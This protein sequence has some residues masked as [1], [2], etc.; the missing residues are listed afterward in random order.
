[1]SDDAIVIAQGGLRNSNGK[2]THGLIRAGTRFRV[3]AVV[4]SDCAGRDAGEVLD[5]KRRGIPVV[6]TI[7]E[8]LA[9]CGGTPRYCV[10]GIATSGG[11]FTPEIRAL[12]LRALSH[13]MSVVAGLHEWMSE[14]PDMAAMAKEKGVELVDLRRPPPISSLHFW[15][16]AIQQVVAPRVAVL[17]T[18]CALG[19]RTTAL[20]LTN[21]LTETGTSAQ[22]IYTGQ[23]GWMQGTRFGFILD[24]TPNDFVSGELEHA[25]V[26]CD[27]EAHPEVM[28]LEGQSA[29]RNPS[30]PCGAELILSG[31]ARGVIL[32]HAPEREFFDGLED[33]K[34]RIPPLEE[35]IQLI[36]LYGAEIIGISL[37]GGQVS[38]EKQAY[39]KALQDRL[40]VPVAYPLAEGVDELVAAVREYIDQSK[41]RHESE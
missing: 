27:R 25:I 26:Q 37:Q 17:G 4:D 40:G 34:C 19:K 16:G 9:Q 13:G 36:K 28:I 12:T 21:R 32:Q 15:T 6:A 5:G 41:R 2:V 8:A 23:T 10:I 29:L 38:E 22:M 3:R 18:D 1:M 30:G 11:Y 24:S 7:E 31:G 39:R 20:M 14:D 35:E 33:R